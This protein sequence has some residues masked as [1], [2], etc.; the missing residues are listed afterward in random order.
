[1][2]TVAERF[3]KMAKR[4]ADLVDLV[5]EAVRICKLPNWWHPDS[6]GPAYIYQSLVGERAWL[7]RQW[8]QSVKTVQHEIQ[9]AIE[10]KNPQL[11]LGALNA[12]WHVKETF[13]TTKR[14]EFLLQVAKGL[15]HDLAARSCE[16]HLSAKSALSGDHNF[17]SQAVWMMA[18]GVSPIADQIL[19]VTD[20]ECEDLLD[21]ARERWKNPKPIPRWCIDGIHSAGDDP[22]FIGLLPNMYAVCLAYRHYGRLSPDDLWMPEFQCYDGLVIERSGASG[23][24][25]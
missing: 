9:R 17:L 10:E 24:E 12:F 23:G 18:G 15:G 8:D 5:S 21:R 11:A 2:E 16:V 14:A 7:Y 1:M 3:W 6:G 22:R 19:P 25:V 20:D 4:Q 13:G